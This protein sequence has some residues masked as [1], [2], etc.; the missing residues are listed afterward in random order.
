MKTR[1]NCGGS[2]EKKNFEIASQDVSIK[3]LR[4][5]G[6]KFSSHCYYNKSNECLIFE[7]FQMRYQGFIK[8][9]C[10]ITGVKE[11]DI[12]QA[13]FLCFGSMQLAVESL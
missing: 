5:L 2:A 3:A 10:S 7:V 1:K 6:K 13:G 12:P 4:E 11:E 9:V 8:E